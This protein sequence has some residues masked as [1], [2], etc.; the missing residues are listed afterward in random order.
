M[1]GLDQ[2]LAHFADGFTLLLVIGVAVLLGLRHA[3]D[4]DHLATSP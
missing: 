4:P 2:W 3:A 1:L